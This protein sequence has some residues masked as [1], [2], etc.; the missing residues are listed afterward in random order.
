MFMPHAAWWRSIQSFEPGMTFDYFTGISTAPADLS[1][2]APNCDCRMRYAMERSAHMGLSACG[3]RTADTA[4]ST[5]KRS[6]EPR[7]LQSHRTIRALLEWTAASL[8]PPAQ[9]GCINGGP[10]AWYSGGLSAY[11]RWADLEAETHESATNRVKLWAE[12]RISGA[13]FLNGVAG[14]QSTRFANLLRRAAECYEREAAQW[15][16]YLTESDSISRPRTSTS[17][18]LDST[19]NLALEAALYVGEAS[20]TATQLS[21]EL[22]SALID[23]PREPPAGAVLNE[24]IY[25]ARAGARPLRELAARCLIEVD[26][27]A[28]KSTLSQLLY[29][30]DGR[31]AGT[32]L[33]GL[34]VQSPSR[35]V[36]TLESAIK[37]GTRMR[38]YLDYPF[39]WTLLAAYVD[40]ADENAIEGL[41][42][43][44]ETLVSEEA[45]A[46]VS[47]DI[48]LFCALLVR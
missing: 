5:V 33:H 13:A 37:Y 23:S 45:E 29:D 42:L 27:P 17:D 34:H 26:N 41:S 44:K 2:C 25:L 11:S 35:R 43:M 15:T 10:M 9:G 32:A 16:M 3:F 24:V 20:L 8:R 7:G 48:D 47:N 22:I 36:R 18:L 21:N 4:S 46:G 28:A 6:P 1:V 14:K 12:A 40:A 38:D 31:I 39:S 19:S 30:S